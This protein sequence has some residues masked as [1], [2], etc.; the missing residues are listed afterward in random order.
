MNVFVVVETFYLFNCRSLTRSFVAV[1]L[2]SNPWVWVGSGIM[3]GL[4]LL[5]TY[6]PLLNRLF[7]TAPIGAAEWLSIAAVGWAAALPFTQPEQQLRRQVEAL[8]K[9]GQIRDA[10]ALMSRHARTVCR[11]SLGRPVVPAEKRMT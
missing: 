1:G 5:L 6:V 9:N 2:F 11:I 3:I 10:L 8:M 4:Q 7:G